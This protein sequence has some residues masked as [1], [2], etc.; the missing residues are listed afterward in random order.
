MVIRR[1]WWIIAPTFIVGCAVA[2]GSLALPNK[3]TSESTI[4]VVQQQ[5]PKRYVTPNTTYSVQEALQSLTEAVLSRSHLLPIIDEFSLYPAERHR[6]GPEGLAQLMR[7]KIQIDPIQMDP[8][9]KSSTETDINAFKISF[10]GDSG[11]VAQ[12]V[13]ERLSSFFID[14]N[15]KLQQQQDTGTTSF[16]KD[17]LASADR[18]LKEQ[19]GRLR[20]FR[21]S[22]LGQLPEQE[23]GN[24][25]ILAGLHT[26][27]Q[28]TMADL[29][30]A[31]E[32]RVYLSS[33]LDQ[34]RALDSTGSATPG[35]AAAES[36]LAAAEIALN[37]LKSQRASLLARYTPQYPD[38]IE[39]N[40]KIAEQQ[41]VVAAL[42]PAATSAAK[43][44][45]PGGG[46]ESSSEAQLRSQL[47]ANRAQ[48]ADLTQSEKRMEQQISDYEQRLNATPVR[49]QQLSEILRQYDLTK[50]N[51]D[52]LL[53]KVTESEMATS[54]AERQQGQQFRVIDP[55]S[56]PREPSS[57]KRSKIA[58][59]GAAAGLVL[60]AALAFFIDSRDHS[61]YA[62]KEIMQRLKLSLVVG[63][64][65]ALAPAEISRR[66]RTRRLE[67]AGGALLLIV[68]MAAELFV[69]RKG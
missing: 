22:N 64:P 50:K 36:P 42:K 15:L 63:V 57:P 20:D 60:G 67:W 16:L 49:G 65:L 40:H 59:G 48:M 58:L 66:A 46:V 32:Q 27:L 28:S 7:S 19:E 3:F 37:Q 38:V 41:A 55:P 14:E 30:R 39:M 31:Q 24:L 12:K 6:L 69:L 35:S 52:D 8:I 10:T 43:D 34:Y 45:N 4:L 9:Q 26:Q 68:M 51:Y 33:L 11:P 18:D 54:L 62:E 44:A 56:L 5:V 17:Q 23:Q 25:E 61:F 13:T 2:L 1:R 21:L 47:K 29:S 53:G